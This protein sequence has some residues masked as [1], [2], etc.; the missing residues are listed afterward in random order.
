MELRTVKDT[1]KDD[2]SEYSDEDIREYISN[3]LHTEGNNVKVAKGIWTNT[4][5]LL[6]EWHTILSSIP[7][8]IKKAALGS[9]ILHQYSKVA[10][11]I[12]SNMGWVQGSGLGPNAEGIKEPVT[13]NIANKDK[14]GLGLR[15]SK[16]TKTVKP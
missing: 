9:P 5:R 7:A 13:A 1:F 8:Y 14:E 2:G 16:K 6:Q 12:M 11:N 10:R 4:E 15:K 3:R